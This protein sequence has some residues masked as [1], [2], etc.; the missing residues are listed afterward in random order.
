MSNAC[1]E[2]VLFPELRAASADAVGL[3]DR[4][5]CR[6]QIEQ[7]D[8]GGRQAVHLAEV[9]AADVHGD[10][11]TSNQLREQAYAQRPSTP[12][13]ARYAA[14]VTEFAAALTVAAAAVQR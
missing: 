9:L 14:L 3:A 12:W 11:C 5:S 13:T 7:G 2:R 1:G 6:T 8:T 4:F 10:P